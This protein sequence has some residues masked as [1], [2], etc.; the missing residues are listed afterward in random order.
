ML[1]FDMLD[2]GRGIEKGIHMLLED[3]TLSTSISKVYFRT[4][5]IW[6]VK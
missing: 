6:S 5:T 2:N 3:V 1:K 4:L